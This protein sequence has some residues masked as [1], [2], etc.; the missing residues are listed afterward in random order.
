[1]IWERSEISGIIQISPG[2]SCSHT[3]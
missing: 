2:L 3:A 1:V